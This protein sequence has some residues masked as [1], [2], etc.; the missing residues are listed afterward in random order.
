MLNR[1]LLREWR[2]LF[3]QSLL[4]VVISTIGIG[5]F[6][7]SYKAFLSLEDSYDYTYKKMNFADLQISTTEDP[8]LE[9]NKIK[10]IENVGH[11]EA[12]EIASAAVLIEDKKDLGKIEARVVAIGD[13]QQINKVQLLQGEYL[14]ERKESILVER[15]F[16]DAHNI[17][18]GDRLT[19]SGLSDTLTL[20]VSGI[21][22]SP[23]YLWVAK[24]RSNVMPSPNEFGVFFVEQDVLNQ[25]GQR[26]SSYDV[27]IDSDDVEGIKGEVLEVLGKF[28]VIDVIEKEEHISY[29][30]LKMDLKG[31][32][33]LAYL[34]PVLFLSISG[35]IIFILLTRLV[36]KQRPII[37]TLRSLGYSKRQIKWHYLQFSLI[38]SVIGGITGTIVGSFLGGKV[39]EIYRERIG[40]PFSVEEDYLYLWLIGIVFSV[41]IGAL[42]GYFPAR[43][44]A[45]LLPV[46]AMRNSLPTKDSKFYKWLMKRI[47]R[48]IK[49]LP[50]TLIMLIRNMIRNIFRYGLATFGIAISISLVFTTSG[51]LDSVKYM[52]N[53]QFDVVENYDLSVVLQEP[54]E[55]EKFKESLLVDGVENTEG[56]L[57]IP[58][59]VSVEGKAIQ[60]MLRGMENDQ[61]QYRVFENIKWLNLSS[62][63]I[64]IP[65]D[66]VLISKSVQSKLGIKAGD[67]ILVTSALHKKERLYTVKGIINLPVGSIII[68]N[69]SELNK[70]FMGSSEPM[71]NKALMEVSG[72]KKEIKEQMSEMENVMTVH[73]NREMRTQ[74][75]DFMGLFNIFILVMFIFA[76]ILATSIL[77]SV[78]F[79]NVVERKN[80]IA[81]LRA[82]G[83]SKNQILRMFAIEHSLI[84]IISVILGII[85]GIEGMLSISLF[86]NNDMLT[87]PLYINPIS[88]LLTIILFVVVVMIA[89]L[90]SQ[91]GVNKINVADAIKVM[92]R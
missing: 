52:L 87:F 23:E 80:E 69:L 37:G 50:I 92:D 38:L 41:S 56:V 91:H 48:Y 32:Q 19:L 24:D 43:K 27:V 4:I 44:A 39:Y 20:E 49:R 71:V 65:K 88:I 62:D 64:D 76:I 59:T 57:D 26:I 81:T 86:Y 72:N 17:N 7:A 77:F 47:D 90:V 12:R 35:F 11:A 21:I 34:F 6:I 46:E 14:S 15:H 73:D 16:A 31:F 70:D 74:L 75:N 10:N 5:M 42:A 1:K 89:Q 18:P 63:E 51:L 2:Q 22:S 29:E 82:F 53:Q 9:I 54:I 40:L 25:L 28:Q 60:T 36:D 8:S 61:D 84:A 45:N 3:W 30:L 55:G 13:N 78:I 58:V 66:G 68:Q 79:I 33:E 83:Y 85:F 67:K